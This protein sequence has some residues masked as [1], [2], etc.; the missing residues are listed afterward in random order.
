MIRMHPVACALAMSA[1]L[2][3]AIMTPVS[4]GFSAERSEQTVE[5]APGGRA[6]IELAENPSTVYVWRFDAQRSKNAG[7]VR[8]ADQGFAQAPSDRPLVGAPGR[9]RWSIEGISVGRAEL[10][11]VNL[12]PWED[13]PVREHVVAVDV[14]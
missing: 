11:F 5:F 3:F 12:R 7:I 4:S 9:H 10:I 13:A 8:I 6:T 14:R 1:S 2:G